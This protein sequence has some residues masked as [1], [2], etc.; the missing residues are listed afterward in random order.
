[1]G[2]KF[3]NV[4]VPRANVLAPPGKGFTLAMQ[5][6]GRTRPIIGA[7]GV[8][9]ARSAMEFAMDYAKKRQAFGTPIANFQAIQFKIAEM[10]QEVETARL[11]TLK[12]A[13]EADQG[14]DP[15]LNASIAKF[16]A[17]EVALEVVNEALQIL[18]GYVHYADDA[19]EECPY[20]FF[21]QS[22]FKQ[23]D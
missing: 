13:W 23:A 5:T 2:L 14:M 4:R 22:A 16:Y 15:T 17:T 12:A 6:F 11:L 10:Y 21:P 7:F 3:D 8:G 1:V 20:C 19:P 9:A 18:C